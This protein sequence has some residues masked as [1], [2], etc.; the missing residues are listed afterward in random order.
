VVDIPAIARGEYAENTCRKDFA[1]SEAVAIWQAMESYEHE[2]DLL[3]QL[4]SKPLEPRRDRAT[5]VV[6]MGH[7]TLTKAKAVVDAADREPE[8]YADLVEK[9]D[10]TGNVSGTIK[11]LYKRQH[12]QAK[13]ATPPDLPEPS[14]RYH[15]ICGDI[16]DVFHEIADDSVDIIITDPPYSEEYIPL[17]AKLAQVAAQLLKPGGSLIVMVGQ[18]YLPEILLE[19]TPYIDYQWVLSYLT[20]GGQ[21]AQ[22]WQRKVNTFW[23]PLLWFVKGEYAGD[24]IGDVCKSN[25]ND[26]D[27]RFHKWGQSES[28]M[29]DIIERFTYPGQTI[30]DPFCGGGITGVVALT[31][32]RRFVGIDIDPQAIETTRTR[33]MEVVNA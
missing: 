4:A 8:K 29:A 33:L 12:T 9:M 19:M 26:N 21:S 31:M 16:G 3:A 11:E 5:K 13:Q 7:Y 2:P 17:Y 6:G 22:L 1:P 25:P 28:G 24:W 27:K 32:N 30:L 20:P 23:K 10:K 15:L 18:S 14:D